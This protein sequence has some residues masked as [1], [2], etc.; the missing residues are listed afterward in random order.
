[1]STLI[2]HA[3]TRGTLE[4]KRS[5]QNT[6][7]CGVGDEYAIPQ[8]LVTK[9]S[10]GCKV[11]LL[12]KDEERRAEGRLVKLEPA[13]K[14]NNGIQRY[15]VYISDLEMVPYRPERLQRTGVAVI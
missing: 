5:F 10:T 14:A 11:V 8:N 2:L 4:H 15:N 7:A 3:P 1:M 9:L 6:F 13:S 12:D